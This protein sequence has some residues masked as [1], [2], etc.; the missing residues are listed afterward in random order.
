[1]VWRK[2]GEEAGLPKIVSVDA[3]DG[4]CFGINLSNGH[5]ILLE[6][7]SR[8]NEPAFAA[9]MESGASC[10]PQT[11]GERVFWPGGPS[12]SLA[13]IF[14]MLK[15]RGGECRTAANKTEGGSNL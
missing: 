14:E 5:I 6:L 11:D 12:V 13:E 10:R 4:D 8:I 2:P 1:M 9:L 3:L 15:S 7:G